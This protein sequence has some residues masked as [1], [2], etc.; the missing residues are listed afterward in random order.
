MVEADPSPLARGTPLCWFL[1]GILLVSALWVGTTGASRPSDPAPGAAAPPGPSLPVHP[2]SSGPC[3]GSLAAGTRSGVVDVLGGPDPPDP[4]GSYVTY[5]GWLEEAVTEGQQTTYSCTYDEAGNVTTVAVNSTAASYTVSFSL[6]AGGCHDGVC[7]TFSGPYTPAPLGFQA[8]PAGYQLIVEGENATWVW[9][10]ASVAETPD[11][12]FASLNGSVLVTAQARN[13]EGG[14]SPAQQVVFT[15]WIDGASDGWTMEGG[16][17]TWEGGNVT[18]AAGA[19]ATTVTL[20]VNATGIYGGLLVHTPDLSFPVT[21]YGTVGGGL[22]ADPLAVDTAQEVNFTTSGTYGAAGYPYRVTVNTTGSHGVAVN[23]T[24]ATVSAGP[25]TVS[26]SCGASTTYWD[27]GSSPVEEY[28]HAVVTNGDSSTPEMYLPEAVTVNPA[29]VLTVTAST[30]DLVTNQSSEVTASVTGGTPGYRTCWQ[31]EPAGPWACDP[32]GFETS[33]RYTFALSFAEAGTYVVPVSVL[34]SAG[35]NR[36]RSVSFQVVYPLTLGAVTSDPGTADAGEPET[37]NVTVVHGAGPV[38]LFVNDSAGQAL[39]SPFQVEPGETGSCTFVPPGWVGTEAVGVTARDAFGETA[40]GSVPVTVVP[41]PGD[42][43]IQARS[44]NNNASTGQTL[45]AEAGV[46]VTFNGSFTG[47]MAPYTYQWTYNQTL[48]VSGEGRAN[49]FNTTFTWTSPGLLPSSYFVVNLTV[50]D[51]DGLQ[52]AA[53]VRV[54][55][56]VDLSVPALHLKYTELD[57]GIS[58]NLTA[59]VSGGAAPFSFSW[60][61]GNGVDKTTGNP[62]LNYAW[63]AP[64]TFTVHVTVVDGV[65]QEASAQLGVTVNPPLQAPCQPLP[66]PAPTEAGVPTTLSL[67]CAQGGTPTYQYTWDFG[68][69]TSLTT[70]TN[71][72]VHTYTSSGDLTTTVTVTDAV[73]GTAVSFPTS[74]SVH[75]RLALTIPDPGSSSCP[76]ST[77]VDPVDPGVPVTFCAAVLG[78]VGAVTLSWQVDQSLLTGDQ[79]SFPGPGHYTVNASATDALGI[80]AITSRVFTVLPLPTLT[81]SASLP[82]IDLGQ[83]IT[84]RAVGAH[85]DG[86]PLGW[87]Y[88]WS[89]GGNL[90]GNGSLLNYSFRARDFAPTPTLTVT[91]EATDLDGQTAFASVNVTLLPDP[92]GSLT[93][94]RLSVDEGLGDTLSAQAEGG[95]APYQ[96]SG[97][98]EGPGGLETIDFSGGSASLPTSLPGTY[99]VYAEVTDAFGVSADLPVPHYLVLPPL[100]LTA[101]LLGPIQDGSVL[102]DQP[103]TLSACLLS[104]GLAPFDFGSDFNGTDA[105]TWSSFPA[106]GCTNVTHVYP[107]PGTYWV[108]AQARDVQGKLSA[109]SLFELQVLAPANAPRVVP[110]PIVVGVETSRSLSVVNE[111]SDVEISWTVPPGANLSAVTTSNGSLEITPAQVGSFPVEATAQV[112]FNG[113]TFGPALS[114]NLTVQ[115]VPGPAAQVAA[116]VSAQDLTLPVG[117]PLTLVWHADDAWGNVAP[118][119]SETVLVQ[120]DG[121]TPNALRL[122]LNAS[123]TPVPVDANGTGFAVPSTDWSEGTLNLTFRETRAANVSYVFQGS[124]VPTHWPGGLL[125]RALPFDWTPNLLHLALFDPSVA[126]ANATTNDTRWQI[127]DEFGNPLSGGFV[128]VLGTWG[129]YTSDTRSPIR[130]TGSESYVWVNFTAYGTEGGTVKVVSEFGQTLLSPLGIPPPGGPPAAPRGPLGLPPWGWALVLGVTLASA[131]LLLWMRRRQQAA[132]REEASEEELARDAEVQEALLQAV[133][134]EEPARLERLQASGKELGLLPE[135]VNAYLLRLRADGRLS[136]EPDRDRRNA[137]T[138]RLG[139]GEKERRRRL[140]AESTPPPRIVIDPAALLRPPLDY[141]EETL[142][143]QEEER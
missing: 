13:A 79:Y 91:G 48:M 130:F 2:L 49:T 142:P 82:V 90:L 122:T 50:V 18:L 65:G 66:D 36:S 78:G 52:T 34:D 131:G 80:S 3:S 68:D 115:V 28:P 29:P 51:Q 109:E 116:S 16:V 85:G 54:V 96:F 9:G 76:N 26:V 119:F 45:E 111:P 56:N 113:S 5:S 30:H 6:P 125:G 53:S 44:G 71:Q 33:G 24:C 77:N 133:E 61:L 12:A 128:D 70:A 60:T 98:V 107:T 121:G 4:S 72:T 88:Q 55:V 139:P 136:M 103:V 137:P 101:S 105:L 69:G 14:P 37:V 57:P 59:V 75:P 132:S 43:T 138:F 47:G 129:A 106:S 21:A 1:L 74:L 23:G 73:G 95:A 15:W 64:G 22:S 117:S 58:D 143:P 19:Q 31:A 86:S 99:S 10:L 32:G 97:Y 94:L 63:T 40:A 11:P 38:T 100:A 7:T 46:P 141:E 114:I 89:A 123:G 118:D 35:V 102:A 62:W 108:A 83:N 25:A 20:E 127:A 124:L 81:V 93:L 27:N 112:S 41:A 110:D 39:C 87:A 8:P 126:W 92:S 84:F 134:E 104:G 42:A 17:R 140:R 135:E 120:V 67:S